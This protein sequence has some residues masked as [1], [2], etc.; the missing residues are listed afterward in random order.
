MVSIV[1]Q[2]ACKGTAFLQNMQIKRILFYGKT[3]ARLRISKKCC[4][5]AAD[6]ILAYCAHTRSETYC[7][8]SLPALPVGGVGGR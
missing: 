6:F 3:R 1:F 5:F 8:D 4:T 2:F 7:D